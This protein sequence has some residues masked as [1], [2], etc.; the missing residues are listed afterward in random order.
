M[1]TK[2]SC[3]KKKVSGRDVDAIDG[4]PVLR[5]LRS[6][7]FCRMSSLNTEA[8]CGARSEKASARWGCFRAVAGARPA[9]YRHV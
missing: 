5:C 6:A 1:P 3:R 8:T 4:T 2:P 7:S 9:Y